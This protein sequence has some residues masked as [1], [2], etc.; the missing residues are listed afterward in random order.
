MEQLTKLRNLAVW[1][2]ND[3]ADEPPSWPRGLAKL[4]QLQDVTLAHFDLVRSYASDVS[5][6][7]VYHNSESH[8]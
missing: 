4:S 8:R 7:D 5:H 2:G 3:A 6:T 1:E